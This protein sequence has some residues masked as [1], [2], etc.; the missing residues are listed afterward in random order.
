MAS[1]ES[2]VKV[3]DESTK[4]I[5]DAKGLRKMLKKYGVA[6]IPSVLNEKECVTMLSEMWDF[7]EQLSIG[8]DTPINRNEEGTWRGFYDLFPLHSM[9]IQ[10]HG[11]GHAKVSW[12]LRQNPKIVDI[13]ATFW[14][15]DP[16]DLLV[17]YDGLS[18]GLPPEITNKG[19]HRKTWL[20]TDQNF[21]KEGFH[22]VQSWVTALDVNGE[23]DATLAFLEG[24]HRFHKSFG[25]KLKE[26]VVGDWYKLTTEDE[27]KFKEVDCEFKRMSCPAGS[28]VFWDSRTIHCGVEAVKGRPLPSIRSV[29]YLCY[30]PREQ[31]TA[32]NLRKKIKA[33]EEKRTT[34]HW[35]CNPKLFGKTPRTYGK[36][37]PKTS[38]TEPPIL[39]ELGLKLAGF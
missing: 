36:P 29:V 35:P 7:F 39:T 13:F 5:T 10:H 21:D 31:I 18:F 6:V 11:I 37:I 27:A 3:S 23:H 1:D 25:S 22:C 32:A 15:C 26:K 34:S 24:S 28:M 17:S 16:E 20:H 19:W 38:E 33:F 9:L 4:Y 12:N 2:K 14:G 8:W 30:A